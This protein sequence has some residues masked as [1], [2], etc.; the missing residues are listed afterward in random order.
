MVDSAGQAGAVTTGC[1][2][3]G[4]LKCSSQPPQGT[5]WGRCIHTQPPACPNCH[6]LIHPCGWRKRPR[7]GSSLTL[8]VLA[9]KRFNFPDFL[10]LGNV[11]YRATA[12]V[13]IPVLQ[14]PHGE[15]L[16]KLWELIGFHHRD[17]ISETVNQRKGFLGTA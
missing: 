6:P 2:P 16:D 17:K 3:L 15:T 11:N 14:L 10:G 12:R 8:A 7:P 9:W 4:K 1:L 13:Q 5:A